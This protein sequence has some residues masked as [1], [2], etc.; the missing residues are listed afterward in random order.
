LIDQMVALTEALLAPGGS[1]RSR[2]S[3]YYHGGIAGVPRHRALGIL[4]LPPSEYTLITV[5]W[6]GYAALDSA[7][8][9]L[10]YRLLWRLHIS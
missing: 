7:G 2:W 6:L 5:A 4:A 8:R 9:L 1:G 3:D 10:S